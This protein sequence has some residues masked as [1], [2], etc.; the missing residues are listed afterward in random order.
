MQAFAATLLACKMP[1]RVLMISAPHL[2]ALILSSTHA[3]P[4]GCPLTEV[5]RVRKAWRGPE[6]GWKTRN[7]GSKTLAAGP[8]PLLSSQKNWAWNASSP[9]PTFVPW[10]IVSSPA[11]LNFLKSALKG[12]SSGEA[13]GFILKGHWWCSSYSSNQERG[14][15]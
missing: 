15:I 8:K 2:A 5:L 14:K 4:M 1:S 6:G 11:S 3:C 10:L 12:N 7:W 13:L 9:S